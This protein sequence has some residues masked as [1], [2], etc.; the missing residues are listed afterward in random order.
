MLCYRKILVKMCIFLQ[1]RTGALQSADLRIFLQCVCVCVWNMWQI[2][3]VTSPASACRQHQPVCDVRATSPGGAQ[4]LRG[5]Q[6]HVHTAARSQRRL[7]R[8]QHHAAPTRHVRQMWVRT[9]RDEFVVVTLSIFCRD[10]SCKK[11]FIVGVSWSHSAL[12]HWRKSAH[13]NL[14]KSTRII[15]SCDLGYRKLRSF[16]LRRHPTLAW[17]CSG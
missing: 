2:A 12:S 17:N 15:I 11:V 1:C 6:N 5:R 14:A 9:C 16:A 8:V 3:Q 10:S 4:F 13:D 7:T